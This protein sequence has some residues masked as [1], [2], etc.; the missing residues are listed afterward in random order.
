MVINLNKEMYISREYKIGTKGKINIANNFIHDYYSQF[1][2]TNEIDN[3]SFFINASLPDE[4]LDND[5]RM[6]RFDNYNHIVEIKVEVIDKLM[7]FTGLNSRNIEK[8]IESAKSAKIK[9][10]EILLFKISNNKFSELPA[11]SVFYMPIKEIITKVNNKGSVEVKYRFSNNKLIKYARFLE[12]L[13]IIRITVDDES[14]KFSIGEQAKLIQRNSDNP[15]M[16]LFN[17]SL[18]RGYDYLYNIIGIRSLSPYL[19]IANSLYYNISNLGR[20]IEVNENDLNEYY[21]NMYRTKMEDYKFNVY[22]DTLSSVNLI[23][24]K[25]NIVTGDTEI[26]EQLLNA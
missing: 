19:K 6:L 4:I 17:Y 23:N 13:E 18:I 26:T 3:N 9:K 20:N 12:Q 16:D 14:Y 11:T 10:S 7:K 2:Y 24:K 25:N 8:S 21:N 22:L 15:V 5:R 1:L